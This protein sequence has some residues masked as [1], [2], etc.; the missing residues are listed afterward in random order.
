[1]SDGNVVNLFG[2]DAPPEEGASVEEA[3]KSAAE[4]GFGDVVIVGYVPVD[5]GHRLQ[6][7]TNSLRNDE[8][9]WLLE[10]LKH[11]LVSEGFL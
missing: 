5:G 9:L 10:S 8:T 7:F 1:M 4:A 2:G 3:L 6:Y 11:G